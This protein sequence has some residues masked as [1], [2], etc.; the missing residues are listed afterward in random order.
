MG[1]RSP[2][3]DSQRIQKG[4]HEI[5]DELVWR[6]F[7][8]QFSVSWY[9]GDL[10]EHY[11]KLAPHASLQLKSCVVHKQNEILFLIIWFQNLCSNTNMWVQAQEAGTH[12][13][14]TKSR[15]T[16]CRWTKSRRTKSQAD[17]KVE[18]QKVKLTTSRRTK[19]QADNKSKNKNSS[20]QNV[21][22]RKVKRT[23]SRTEKRAKHYSRAR[24]KSCV[25]VARMSTKRDLST[26][27]P[28]VQ[29]YCLSLVYR[30]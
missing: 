26:C 22:G 2:E 29:P 24:V 27:D 17:K 15:K 13:F 6:L 4:Y 20:G 10:D 5:E 23:K 19:S 12:E 18:G 11:M 7:W 16:K 1:A 14:R 8:I 21:G 9:S 30:L 28:C 3:W 25:P